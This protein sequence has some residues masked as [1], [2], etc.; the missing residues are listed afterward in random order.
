[1]NC[2]R[3]EPADS[4]IHIAKKLGKPLRVSNGDPTDGRHDVS[5]FTALFRTVS[6]INFWPIQPAIVRAA[7]VR[8]CDLVGVRI[9]HD[10]LGLARRG[11]RWGPGHHRDHRCS[12]SGV[13]TRESCRDIWLCLIAQARR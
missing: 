11:H 7:Q 10:G 9:E 12:P 5:F 13:G 2:G 8:R 1:M 4:G 3:I 6:V